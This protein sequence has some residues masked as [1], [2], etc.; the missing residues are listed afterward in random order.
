MKGWLRVLLY[1]LVVLMALVA[2]GITATIGWRP[3]IG[4]RARALTNR[5]FE[6]TPARLA[7][8]HY[9]T[10]GVTPCLVCHSESANPSEMWVPK[11]GTEGGGQRWMEPELTWLVVPNISPDR[12]TGRP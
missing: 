5:T 6:P 11:P 10:S 7:R 2:V 1:T 4:P 8:G 3:I 12:D 9:L